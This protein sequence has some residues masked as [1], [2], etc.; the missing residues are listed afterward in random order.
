MLA[1]LNFGFLA[2]HD[3]LLVAVA[4]GAERYCLPDPAASLVKQRA[5]AELLAKGAAAYAGLPDH[6]ADQASR[7]RALAA[8]GV[9]PQEVRQLFDEVRRA[10]NT[11]AHEQ[12]ATPGGALHHLKR[13]RALASWYHRAFGQAP[14]FQAPPFVPPPDPTAEASKSAELEAELD[15][16]RREVAGLEGRVEEGQALS[17]EQAEKLR[18]AEAATQQAHADAE[19]A[20]ALAEETEAEKARLAE[21]KARFE[22][23]VEALRQKQQADPSDAAER[24]RQAIEAGKTLGL[25]EADTRRLIDGQLRDAGWEADTDHLRYSAGTRP[26]KGRQL[27]IAEWPTSSGPADYVLFDGLTAIGIVEAKRGSVDVPGRLDQAARYARDVRLDTEHRPKEGPWADG[28]GSDVRVPF[29]FATNGRAYL[30]QLE[31]KSGVWFRDARGTTNRRRA[32]QG[33][34]TPEGLRALLQQDIAKA[35]AA[36]ADEPPEMPWLRHYQREA[37]QAVEGAIAGGETEVLVAMATGTGKTRTALALLY[38]L[39][40]KER[41]RRVLFLV[42]RSALGEQAR[43]AFDEVGVEGAQPFSE[44]YDVK[45]LED[46]EPEATTRLH[47]ATVQGLVKRLLHAEET[48]DAPPVDAYDAIVVD[49][50]HRGYVLDRELSDSELGFRNESD[51]RSQYRRVIEHF[52]AVRIALTATPAL[53]TVEI[54]GPP[55]YQYSYRQAVLD[56]FLC[57]HLPPTRITTA[58]AKDGIHWDAGAEAHVYDPET[59]TLDKTR[60]PD[61]VDIDIEGFNTAVVTENYNRAVLGVLAGEIDPDLPGKT[62]IFCVSDAHADLVVKVLKEELA[63][64][65]GD[66]RD[67]AVVKITGAAD[68]PR[69]LIRRFRNEAMP[70]VAVTVDLL[71]T[72][73]DVPDITNVVFLRRVRSRILYEQMMGRGTRLSPGLFGEGLGKEHFRVFR[74]RGP[75]PRA[76]GLLGHAARGHAARRHLRAAAAGGGPPRPRRRARARCRAARR[77]RPTRGEAPAQTRRAPPSGGRGGGP[78]RTG[79]RRAR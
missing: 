45:G 79:A 15:T 46:A 67:D 34:Y 3:P 4:A 20:L 60:L 31:T 61:E 42:D 13:C 8:A 44:I 27:A 75:L 25:D 26:E 1:S 40:K 11:A 37:I 51:Y 50:A 9:L 68:R 65:H 28:A 76:R 12:R 33:W 43:A 78:H 22:A 30:K 36:L 71:T 72:G 56:G 6:H 23:E 70:A 73:I 77:G 29:L 19:A 7:V 59:G 58:L 14:G 74:R 49:E 2:Q 69:Q 38:R 24:V 32:L 21:E 63:S 52:D 47:V 10:G 66:V 17:S 41:F 35:D 53:H 57:D 55:V 16:L 54:F 62:L 48:G 64:V 39:V 5:L 18:E